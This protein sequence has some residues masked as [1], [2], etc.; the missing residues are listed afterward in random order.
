VLNA[1][2]EGIQARCWSD[3]QLRQ[4]DSL[5]AD[6]QFSESLENS[7]LFEAAR[8]AEYRETWRSYR[9]RFVTD[10]T[11]IWPVKEHWLNIGNR[12]CL[13]FAP[14]GWADIMAARG[15]EMYLDFGAGELGNHWERYHPTRLRALEREYVVRMEAH[16]VEHC[17][18]FAAGVVRFGK[19]L[20]EADVTNTQARIAIALERYRLANGDFPND[21]D[22]LSDFLTFE[23]IDYFAQ[24]EMRYERKDDGF[25]LWSVGADL[26]DDGGHFE[27]RAKDQVWQHRWDSRNH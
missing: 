9:S 24:A 12:H 4:I 26:V 16:P 1:I 17:L 11:D 13:Q 20:M 8:T 21:L 19:T 27:P 22:Q 14:I 15:G 18:C 6:A 3:Q 25:M 7:L 10:L 5:C 2:W 23:P